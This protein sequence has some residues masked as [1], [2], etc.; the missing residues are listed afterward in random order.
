MT[1]PGSCLA[2]LSVALLL[3][4]CG[5][6]DGLSDD[7][8]TAADNLAAQI[9]TSGQV[10]GDTSVTQEQ[11]EC[12]GTGTVSGVGLEALQG[13][14][15]VTDDLKV[16][17]SVQGVEMNEQDAEALAGVFVDCLDTEALFERQF[18]SGDAAKE[19]TQKE[20]RCVRDVIDEEAVEEVLALSFQGETSRVYQGL[21]KDLVACTPGGGG[22]Q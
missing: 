20:R 7:E 3:G 12:I 10:A 5:A 8:R 9:S 11:S 17:K 14:G 19:L 15:I 6:D 18:L 22:G 4:A 16:D 21:Q 2:A 1:K 13:Y